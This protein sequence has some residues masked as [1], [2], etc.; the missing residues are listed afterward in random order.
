MDGKG[1]ARAFPQSHP[2]KLRRLGGQGKLR[3]RERKGLASEWQGQN[4]EQNSG[5][6]PQP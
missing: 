3:Q 1:R 5:P 2:R 4:L 6:D